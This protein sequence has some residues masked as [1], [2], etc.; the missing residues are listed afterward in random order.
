M[1]G[2]A[3]GISNGGAKRCTLGKS[4]GAACIDARE[5][6][7]IEFPPSVQPSLPAGRDFINRV[8]GRLNTAIAE[9]KP[10]TTEK[11]AVQD[12]ADNY[13]KWLTG[14]MEQ[15]MYGG[16]GQRGNPNSKFWLLGQEG[17]SDTNLVPKDKGRD[18]PL[19]I[20]NTMRLHNKLYDIAK[21]EGV[22]IN[23]TN[24]IESV[25]GGKPFHLDKDT[26]VE[27]WAA[28][29]GTSYYGRLGRMAKE[30]G[31]S[32]D[33]LGANASS[34]MMVPGQEGLRNT[35]KMLKRN[36]VDLNTFADGAFKSKE[37][38]Y[39]ASVNA[40]L[41]LMLK[42]VK[43][44]KPELVY[45]S[46][47]SNPEE[48]KFANML[49]YTASQKLKLPVYNV[50]HNGWN[51]N[52]MVIPL[53]GGKQ[54]VVVNSWHPQGLRDAPGRP[55]RGEGA[56]KREIEYATRLMNS[57]RETGKPPAGEIAKPISQETMNSVLGMRGGTPA[58]AT[59]RPMTESA[60]KIVR[61][62]QK[63]LAGAPEQQPVKTATKVAPKIADKAAPLGME[64]WSVPRLQK[65][66]DR[67]YESGDEKLMAQIQKVLDGK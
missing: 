29:P 16:P 53:P 20:L 17:Y 54:T 50:N 52:Y 13:K 26:T 56:I 36:G 1:R 39:Q 58:Q 32:G 14:G 24:G 61:E 42:G 2:S 7:N 33:V 60:A 28:S 45:V 34:F 12:I 55:L 21:Q 15:Q 63:K 27:S 23:P 37:A 11:E 4:C 47:T 65:A 35:I 57:L 51:Y 10:I 30:L 5:R 43:R 46:Q 59:P 19:T 40:R 44:Y 66:F 31:Y 62:T 6:C 25:L 3:S 22:T 8:Q 18:D 48:K 49:M 38:W 67:A 64:N 9:N 41:P